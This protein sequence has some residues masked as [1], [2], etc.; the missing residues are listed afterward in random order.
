MRRTDLFGEAWACSAPMLQRHGTVHVTHLCAKEGSVYERPAG[1]P[2]EG[3]AD[4]PAVS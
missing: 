1:Y 2:V 3:T 4:D